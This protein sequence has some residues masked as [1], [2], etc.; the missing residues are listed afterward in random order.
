MKSTP[1]YAM[2]TKAGDDAV[3]VVV[4]RA[5]KNHWN[6]SKTYSVLQELSEKEQFSEAMDTAVRECVYDALD[7]GNRGQNFYL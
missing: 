3:H 7:Y 4:L 1:N 2:Y 5:R 6:W